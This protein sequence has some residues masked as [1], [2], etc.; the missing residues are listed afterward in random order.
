MSGGTS[1]V[2]F[3]TRLPDGGQVYS[4]PVVSNG[5][6]VAATERN[7]VYGLDPVNG[8]IKWS[9]SF[10]TPFN[11]DEVNCADLLPTPPSTSAPGPSG[12]GSR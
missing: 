1:G 7:G 3:D 6:L 11:P 9:R 5:T 4:Q 10:G 12:P 2:M 8:A